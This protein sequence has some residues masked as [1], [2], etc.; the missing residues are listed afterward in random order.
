MSGDARE[1]GSGTRAA[2]LLVHGFNGEPV[3]MQELEEYAAAQGFA[4]RNLQLPGHG[5]T[6]RDLAQASWADWTRAVRRATADL[7]ETGLPVVLVGHSMGAA[8]SLHEAASN[9]DVSAVAAL[10]P[11]LRMHPGEVRMTAYL[12]VVVPYLPTIREDIFD[13]EARHRYDRHAHR[14]TSLAAA[15]SLFSSLP[16]LRAELGSV[17]C[18]VLVVAARRDHVV[19]MRDGI[20]AHRLLGSQDKE[21]LVLERSYH[22]VTKDV[23]RHQVF[24]R[25]VGLAERVAP[26]QSFQ[27]RLGA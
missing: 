10:C 9:P 2:L 17:R 15:H 1:F 11:P 12:R 13:P 22:G 27:R 4:T 16:A 25:V 5:M 7:R 26:P 14:W 21:L 23:E 20:E 19:P 3:D 24:E 18:P 6:A 8:L